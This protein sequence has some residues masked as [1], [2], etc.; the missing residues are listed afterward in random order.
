MRGNGEKKTSVKNMSGNSMEWRCENQQAAVEGEWIALGC[1]T[2]AESRFPSWVGGK[3]I[4]WVSSRERKSV[5]TCLSMVQDL[6]QTVRIVM[7]APRVFISAFV[8]CHACLVCF[9]NG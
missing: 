6:L 9:F 1:Q 4:I 2:E 7:S 5:R 3:K 8:E